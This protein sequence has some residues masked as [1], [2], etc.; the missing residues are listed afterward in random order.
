MKQHKEHKFIFVGGLHR[1]GTTAL[2]RLLGTDPR[3]SIFS[4]T[5]VIEDEGQY[6]Q[7]V[8]PLEKEYGS[9]GQFALDPASHWTEAS[10]YVMPAKERLFDEWSSY[11]DLD[12]AVLAEKTPANLIRVRFLRAAFPNST[13]IVMMRHPIAV[14]FASMKWRKIKTLS[15]EM[16][17]ENWIVAHQLMRNDLSFIPGNDYTILKY[18]E[19]C[20]NPSKFSGE[21]GRVIGFKADLAYDSIRDG[22]NARYFEKWKTGDYHLWS[23]NSALKNWFKAKKNII[24][25]RRIASQYESRIAEFG[26]SFSTIY[27]EVI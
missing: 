4:N 22:I 6:L 16:M 2:Y 21:L 9:V 5:G 14:I 12:K 19:F 15:L 17:L 20:Q 10:E 24:N 1:S 26:Y 8:F 7:T 25:F 11:W 27:D 23:T 3:I 13:F 18:E